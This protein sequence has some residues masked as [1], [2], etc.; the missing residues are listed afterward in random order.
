[1]APEHKPQ[2]QENKRQRKKHPY[3]NLNPNEL[4][5]NSVLNISSDF[6]FFYTYKNDSI[7]NDIKPHQAWNLDS[8]MNLLDNHNIW[9]YDAWN[10]KY[11]SRRPKPQSYSTS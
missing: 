8:I 4:N 9:Q 10:R 5:N 3:Y 1:M 11:E 7:S 6:S 2:G